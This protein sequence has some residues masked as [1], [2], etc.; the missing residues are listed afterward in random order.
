MSQIVSG[1]SFPA[2]RGTQAKTEYYIV[3]CPLKRLNKIFTF[4]ESQLPVDQR[5]QRI[6]NEERIP[7]IANYILD[8]RDNYVFSALTACISGASEFVPIGESKHEQKIGTLLID[9]DAEL[10]ITDGQH[11]N[12]AI[13][14]AI[15]ADPSL[16]DE[17]ISVV[18][19]SNKTLEERQRI[20]KDLNLYPVKTDSSLSITYDDK[21][22]AILSKT[23]VFRSEQ[24][25]KLVHMEKSNLGARSK[26]L[27][28]HSAIN[29]ATKYLLGTINQ[30]N[31]ESLIPVATEFWH[32][33]LNNMP[34]WQLICEDKASGGDLRDESIHAHAVTLHALGMLGAYLLKHDSQW[35]KTLKGL[36]DIN[37]SRSN[38]AWRGRCVNNNAMTNNRKAAELTC[39][40]IKEFLN[41]TL[42]NK[43]Q[44]AEQAF[45]GANN[46]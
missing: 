28:S 8:N 41:V 22:D 9:E 35:Q 6:I 27:V 3:M 43:E 23:V 13:L 25:T 19:F 5:A 46:D 37:W 38:N 45:K 18:F 1:T 32:E 40:K 7:D 11:R 16:A 33:V 14:E 20:F 17:S 12:A 39:I 24:F 15:K 44:S 42:T 2:I 30:K 31:Y 29:K 36:G 4:D 34:A 26:K 21:P 10:F